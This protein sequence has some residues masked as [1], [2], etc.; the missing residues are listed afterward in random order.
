M[1]VKRGIEGK[2]IALKKT[3][4]EELMKHP[5]QSLQVKEK[6]HIFFIFLGKTKAFGAFV[7]GLEQH[8]SQLVVRLISG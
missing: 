7:E 5:I 2:I 8:E 4:N 1:G 6:R 3:K